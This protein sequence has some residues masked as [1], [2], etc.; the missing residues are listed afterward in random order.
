MDK[1]IEESLAT[2]W[3]YEYPE[4]SKEE[5]AVNELKKL[6]KHKP[7]VGF[8][9]EYMMAVAEANTHYLN[10]KYQYIDMEDSRYEAEFVIN[11][12]KDYF[13]GKTTE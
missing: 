11:I 10:M 1:E 2:E 7:S 3:G 12:I 5:E 13:V 8:E 9:E 6:I 4:G